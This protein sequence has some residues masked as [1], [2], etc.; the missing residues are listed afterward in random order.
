[1][2]SIT[3]IV[4]SNWPMVLPRL[5]LMSYV[6]GSCSRHLDELHRRLLLT[7]FGFSVVV[8]SG[9]YNLS[10]YGRGTTSYRAPELQERHYDEN[11]IS[12]GVCFFKKS[13]IWSIGCILYAIASTCMGPAFPS[14][15]VAY[16]YSHGETGAP[17]LNESTNPNLARQSTT[18][19]RMSP[20]L[21]RVK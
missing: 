5:I 2:M 18:Q 16:W 8:Q 17:Q 3:A 12:S 14:D 20:N 9:K 15:S 6:S 1:M 13:D 4:T 11:H 10:K 21:G 19:S 7:D